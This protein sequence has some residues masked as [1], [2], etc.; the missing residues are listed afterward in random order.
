M[1]FIRNFLLF[2]SLLQVSSFAVDPAGFNNAA[3]GTSP[4][5][6]KNAVNAQGWQN[7]GVTAQGFPAT[8]NV[9]VFKSSEIVA[10]YKAVVKYYFYENKLFQATVVFN[11]DEM[12]KFDFNY[13]VFRSVN[14]YYL[15]IRS[16]SIVFVKTIYDLLCKKYGKKEPVFKG[17]DPRYMFVNLDKY[18]KQERWNLR[19]H[20]YD[21]YLHIVTAAYARWDFP[22]TRVIFSISLAAQEKRFDYQ[23][24]LT[25]LDLETAVQKKID[26]LRMK[27]L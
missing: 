11:F 9:A 2:V 24:S 10:G 23:L 19:Y 16:K 26:E 25:S 8:M 15:F 5:M 27:G 22:K 7:D 13:N 17:L 20:P 6:V 14:E 12:K 18:L 21:Y 3:W 4:D 1:V